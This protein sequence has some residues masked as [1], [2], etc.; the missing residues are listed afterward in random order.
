MN[1][2]RVDLTREE[3]GDGTVLIMDPHPGKEI[4]AVHVFLKMGSMYEDEEHSGLSNLMQNLLLKGTESMDS[5][6][7]DN[8]LDSIGSKLVSL[9]GKENGSLSLLTTKEALPEALDL[10]SEVLIQP[11]MTEKEFEKERELALDEIRQ[12]KDELLSHALDL[13]QNAFY[14]DHPL[15]KTVAGMEDVVSRLTLDDAKSFREKTYVPR[16]MVFSCAGDFDPNL[17]GDVVRGTVAGISS[18]VGNKKDGN[19]DREIVP[20]KKEK[21]LKRVGGESREVYE[22]RDS[23]AAWIVLGYPAPSF[24]DTGYHE[25]QV[26]NA[27]LGGS[28]DSRLFSQLREKKGLAYQVSSVYRTYSGPSFLAGY[29]GTDPERYKEAVNELTSEIERIAE[30]EPKGEEL[31]RTKEYLKGI[32]LIGSETVSA[33]AARRGKFEILGLG[34][35][36]GETYLKG[37]EG[38]TAE[39]LKEVAKNHFQTPALG[40]VIPRG[41]KEQLNQERK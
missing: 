36:Y 28:M 39:G 35:D 18:K 13:F 15:H 41:L 20:A 2:E 12:R 26:V 16:N 32:F 14:G 3:I 22:E 11:A 1:D 25:M 4:V 8:K 5:E 23:S 30:E 34:Y 27:A 38:V 21:G 40:A 31:E 6:A 9:T 10:M 37:I 24:G 17:V 19:W 33:Q 7:L 29:I